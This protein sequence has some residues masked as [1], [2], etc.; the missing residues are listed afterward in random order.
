MASLPRI[1]KAYLVIAL[2]LGFISVEKL[3]EGTQINL[4]DVDGSSFIGVPEAIQL[5]QN[6]N[7]YT[8]IKKKAYSVNF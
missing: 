2:N 1:N 6:L 7:Q 8:I 5:I 3:V 4:S